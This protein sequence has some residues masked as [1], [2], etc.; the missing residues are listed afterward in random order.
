MPNTTYFVRVGGLNGPTTSYVLTT[1]SSISTLANIVTGIGVSGVIG[2]SMS[3]TWLPLP[4]IPSSSTSEGYEL[5]VSTAPDFSGIIISSV[6]PVVTLSTLTVQNI[7]AGTTYYIRV[8]ALNWNN[9][10]NY[11]T[12]ISTYLACSAWPNGY[13]FRQAIIIDHT[14]V[15]NTDQLNFPF[16]FHGTYTV[17]AT[18]PYDGAV[19]STSGYDIIFSTDQ[20]G[21]VRLPHEIE[22]YS[23][24]TGNVNMWVQIPVVSHSTNTVFYMFYGSSTITTSQENKTGVW[25]TNYKAVFHLANGS[26]LNAE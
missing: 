10:N 8:G 7:L 11:A 12:V 6:T 17:L 18:Q 1:P 24:A 20:N 21:L 15:P 2:Q 4:T 23:S 26:T 25:D 19:V 13:C 22:T 16:L 3:V 5:D 14:Q 9:V